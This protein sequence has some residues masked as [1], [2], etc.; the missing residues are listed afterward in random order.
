MNYLLIDLFNFK[1]QPFFTMLSRELWQSTSLG[2]PWVGLLESE[3]MSFKEHPAQWH[4]TSCHRVGEVNLAI[5]EVTRSFK[6]Y[7]AIIQRS[8]DFI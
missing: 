8:G 2:G 7:L 5:K 3:T 4:L 6:I 1:K